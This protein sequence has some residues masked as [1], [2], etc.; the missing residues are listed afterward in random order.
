M[1]I[2]LIYSP[3]LFHSL[4]KENQ[5]P[6]GYNVNFTGLSAFSIFIVLINRDEP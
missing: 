5:F 1:V 6:K 4:K 3:H 2:R